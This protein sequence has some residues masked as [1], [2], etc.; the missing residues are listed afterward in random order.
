MFHA[1]LLRDPSSPNPPMAP[2]PV[3]DWSRH[4]KQRAASSR[5]AR[6]RRYY[7]AGM[8][9][10]DTPLADVP[11]LAMDVE[12]TGLNPATDGIVSIA[13]V[14]L[15]LDTIQASQG[16]HWLLKP[17]VPMGDEAV[18]IHGITH[19]QIA[20]A[21]DLLDILDD[22]L[23]RMAGH[24]LVVHCRDI[25]RLF[26][27]SAL[28]RRLGETIDFPVID[29]M[30]L[31]AR[32]HRR[33]PPWWQRWRRPVTAPVSIRLGASRER[34]GLPRYRLHHAWTDALACAELLQAQVAHRYSPTT[35][36]SAL[37]T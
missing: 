23:S 2:A 17:R 28:Q 10:A 29:T 31:E 4:F 36:V 15:R 27:N 25:E 5:D 37:W 7:E 1:G 24:V 20:Q 30:A 9:A 33:P 26:L 16:Q 21:P 32:L 13:V 12:T 22:L 14:P 35:P 8:V 19:Q 18:T 11:L 3:L 6:L 34:Y